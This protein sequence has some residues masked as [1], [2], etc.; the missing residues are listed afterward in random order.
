M[1]APA[2]GARVC[3]VISFMDET[4]EIPSSA[5]SLNMR[6]VLLRC[7]QAAHQGDVQHQR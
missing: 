3:L 1:K 5:V 4:D 6:S 7:R 2:R